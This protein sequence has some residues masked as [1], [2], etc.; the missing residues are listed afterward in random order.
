M[1]GDPRIPEFGVELGTWGSGHANH[2]IS[3]YGSQ[4]EPG[5]AL[6]NRL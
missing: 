2:L 5:C 3:R 6:A 4:A 1:I